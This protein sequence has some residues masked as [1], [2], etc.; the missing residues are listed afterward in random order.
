MSIEQ[1]TLQP[2]KAAKPPRGVLRRFRRDRKGTASI[3]FAILALP[4][5]IVIFASIETF[6][7]FY[8][9]QLLANATETL[10]RK[11]RTGEITFNRGKPATD[12]DEVKF[13]QAFCNEISVLMTCS[14]TEAAQASKLYIDVRSVTDLTKF[15]V[16]VPRMDTSS[17]SDLKTAELKF[18]PGGPGS[19]NVMRAYYR[20][21]VTT[22]LIRPFV[23]NLR[24]AGSSMPKDYLMVSTTTFRTENE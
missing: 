21:S 7:A 8:G 12:M 16:L 18:A 14:A 19:F 6:L 10:A 20:W 22:D 9:D 13:R 5:F 2:Q 17:S 1:E 11:I 15:P 3:E 23:T 24:P 4:F